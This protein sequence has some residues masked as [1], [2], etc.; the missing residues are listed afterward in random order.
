MGRVGGVEPLCGP[1]EPPPPPTAEDI[2]LEEPPPP[3]APPLPA[4]TMDGRG[5]AVDGR[6]PAMD[7][8]PPRK[9]ESLGGGG[10]ALALSSSLEFHTLVLAR[11]VSLADLEGGVKEWGLREVREGGQEGFDAGGGEHPPSTRPWM[12]SR[13]VGQGVVFASGVFFFLH[14]VRRARVV[15]ACVS[16]RVRT[17][18]ATCNANHTQTVAALNSPKIH[19]QSKRGAAEQHEMAR[20]T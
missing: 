4:F 13:D 1:V 6:W 19:R 10:M 20:E 15:S 8:L 17:K 16:E 18:T 2:F 3:P 5:P 7:A 14:N 9:M 11:T 12:L